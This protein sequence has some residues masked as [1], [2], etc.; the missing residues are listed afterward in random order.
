MRSH[1]SRCPAVARGPARAQRVS[2]YR[3]TGRVAFR[4]N[5]AFALLSWAVRSLD[6]GYPRGRGNMQA[7][8]VDQPLHTPQAGRSLARRSREIGS[9]SAKYTTILHEIAIYHHQ[10][11]A[12]TS[13]KSPCVAPPRESIRSIAGVPTPQTDE[14]ACGVSSFLRYHGRHIFTSWPPRSRPPLLARSALPPARDATRKQHD[15]LV[16]RRP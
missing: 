13:A 12:A 8:I 10:Q 14:S 3:I 4:E 1:R 11:P 15:S 5:P 9:A 16:T 2:G 7:V 6:N